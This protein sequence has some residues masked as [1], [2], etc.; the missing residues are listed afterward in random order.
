MELLQQ[1]FLKDIMPEKPA[2]FM[3]MP[4]LAEGA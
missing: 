1:A 3:E 2:F 4:C